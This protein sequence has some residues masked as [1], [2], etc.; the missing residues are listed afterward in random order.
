MCK[1]TVTYETKDRGKYYFGTDWDGVLGKASTEEEALD[2]ANA[3]VDGLVKDGEAV[4]PDVFVER[5]SC[6]IVTE[7]E[8]SGEVTKRVI[9]YD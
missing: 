7:R 9:T 5:L 4:F 8:E 1:I 6:L 3:Y 2:M